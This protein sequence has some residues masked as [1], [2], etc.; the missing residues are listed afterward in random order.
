MVL[1]HLHKYDTPNPQNIYCHREAAEQIGFP[2][3]FTHVGSRL[4]GEKENQRHSEIAMLLHYLRFLF[5][6]S[7]NTQRLPTL[8]P[9]LYLAIHAIS[10][11][12]LC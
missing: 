6:L 9:I 10:S 1:K 8:I 7:L 2:L 11:D 3:S 12:T 4:P 5:R